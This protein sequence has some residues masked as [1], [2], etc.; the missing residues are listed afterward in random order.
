MNVIYEENGAF[1]VGAVLAESDTSL[2]V[3]A[4]HGKRSKIK[5]NAVLLRFEQPALGEFMVR[6][7]TLA[8]EIDTGFLW[9]C[10]AEEE[11]AFADLAKEYCGHAPTALEAT[12]NCLP[13][14]SC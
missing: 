3:E 14:S 5:A 11:F 13:P 6:A 12:E 2:Q 4:P 10:C 1:K 9:E 7:E 8:A